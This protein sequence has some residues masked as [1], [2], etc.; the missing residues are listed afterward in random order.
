M[1]APD[2]F[3]DDLLARMTLEEK[4]GQLNLVTATLPL[5]EDRVTEIRAGRIGGLLGGLV[6][7]S[8]G[9]G[10][11]DAA[12][13]IQAIAVEQ[14][15]LGIPLL[16]AYDV[17]HGHQTV[18]PIP[19]ALS[20]TWNLGHVEAAARIAAREATACGLNWVFSPML[21][22]CRDPRWGRIAE[23]S[24]EDP[25]LGSR[26]A[27]AMVRG[28]QGGDLADPES[29]LACIKHFIAYGAAEGGRD[30]NNADLSPARLA[31]LYLPPFLAALAAG[32]GSAMM[33]FAAV[34]GIPSHADAGLLRLLDGVLKVSDFNAIPEMISHGLGDERGQ[35]DEADPLQ[36]L[37]ERALRAGVQM[38]MMGHGFASRL[39]AALAAGRVSQAEIDAACRAVLAT[40]VKLGLFAD[41]FARCD[42]NRA[43]RNLLSPEYRP[44]ARQLAADSCVLLK[45]AGDLLPLAAPGLAVAVVGPLADDPWN[46]LGPWSFQGDPASTVTVLDGI[47]AVPGV[48][49][50]HA[51]G[52]NIAEDRRMLE[53]LNFAGPKVALDSRPPREMIAE[54]V[55]AAEA[56]DVVVAVLG[57]AAEMSGEAASR[58][59]IGLPPGQRTLLEALHA[60][61]KPVVLVLLHGRP[62]ALPWEA[63]H[64]PAILAAWFGGHEAGNAIA[65]LLFGARAPGGRLTTTWPRH[66]GQVPLAY[67]R[68]PTGRP[69]SRD[70]DPGKYST[71]CYLDGSSEPLFP[72]G[73][74]LGYTRFAYGSPAVSA[75]ELGPDDVLTV[76]VEIANTGARAGEEV[77]QMYVT[78]PVASVVRPG[79][80]LKGFEKIAL[81]PGE[82][83]TV[84]F[85]LATRDLEFHD[86]HGRRIWEPGG[87]V[88]GIGPNADDLQTVTVRW[89]R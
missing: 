1:T 41:P 26:I 66:V 23:G 62:L 10:G 71:R 4:L 88:I 12:R 54:A 80:Q 39:P 44:V 89:R 85:R 64:I 16:L 13:E 9:V 79:K 32:A 55:A 65:D 24:G 60:T 81:A 7:C 76:S 20:C 3:V 78:D 19:L 86:P 63:E 57:E 17:I 27:E 36:T 25:Y 73:F 8:F 48:T 74:G 50:R 31:D 49:V 15:R 72:F 42:R 29:V 37:S 40:K 28:L 11:P 69:G 38:D 59:D 47:R 43:A 58:M 84:R 87:F 75:T 61:G 70:N 18:L 35:I 56:S 21:D 77:V 68:A 51:R 45:N 2:T 30:Y 22:I 6:D 82:R 52:A 46:I 34:N 67:D 33:S 14:S 5:P 83:R 53:L